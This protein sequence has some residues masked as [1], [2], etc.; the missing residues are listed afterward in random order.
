MVG[1]AINPELIKRRMWLDYQRAS[2]DP[3]ND[4]L[5][6]VHELMDRLVDPSVDLHGFLQEAANMISLK[7]CIKEVTIGLKD[8]EDGLY[9][10]EAMYG[11]EDSEW[12]A[13]KKLSYSREQFDTQD[14][15]KFKEIS[16]HTRLFLAEDYPYAVGEDGT[17]SKELML[18]SKR[19]SLEDTIEGDYLDTLV[20]GSKDELLGWT[21]ISG[22][23]N[24][25]FPDGQTL[26]TLELLASV[27]GVAIT[28]L[29]SRT[30]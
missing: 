1:D 28:L 13:H 3:G 12:D 27:I 25:K 11:L 2:N 10:Y 19:S 26:I 18:Q 4:R 29:G 6:C 22:M 9:R 15:Y 17:Y 24:G 8:P 30:A 20:F 21:E 14:V 7:L 23:N 5:E 16:K